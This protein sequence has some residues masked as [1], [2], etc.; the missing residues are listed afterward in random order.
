M[1]YLSKLIDQG[2]LFYELEDISGMMLAI[3]QVSYIPRAAGYCIA[4]IG[5]G[6]SMERVSIPKFLQHYA[7]LPDYA[8]VKVRCFGRLYA[9]RTD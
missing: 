7:A 9:R 3:I 2:L 8:A 5:D 1:A 4:D 6:G